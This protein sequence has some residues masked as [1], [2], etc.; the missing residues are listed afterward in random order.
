MLRGSSWAQTT[1]LSAGYARQ[2][3]PQGLGGERIE[4]LGAS[5]CGVG[6]LAAAGM[7]LDVVVELAGTEHQP[8]DAV[9]VFHGGVVQ[10]LS[11]AA[12]RELGHRGCRHGV[13]EQALRGHHDH[14]PLGASQ[15]LSPE[16]VEVLR[17]G[18]GVGDPDVLLG[19]QLE[20]ALQ[21]R[22]GVLGSLPL[23]AVGQEQREARVLAPLRQAGGEE[24]VDH[25]L[26][27]VHEVTELGL[28]EH[29][30]GVGAHRVPVLEADDRR[31][32]EG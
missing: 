31:L 6:R 24:L 32:G 17:G 12:F 19:A 21:A 14:G 22:A 29:H 16:E 2:Q 7:A 4:E 18:G 15:S 3:V 1:C 20:K 26:G 23:E 10:D 28:P 5:H 8:V 9:G 13:S 25:D 11:E 30:V 27:H